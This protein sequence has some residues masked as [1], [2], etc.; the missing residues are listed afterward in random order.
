VAKLLDEEEELW[1]E[2]E[3]VE[4]AAD[5]GQMVDA[6]I[7]ID[8][9]DGESQDDKHKNEIEVIG[10]VGHLE[11]VGSSH[12]GGGAGTG[13][14]IHHGFKFAKLQDKSSPKLLQ[15]CA[16]GEHIK[17]AEFVVR[18]AGKQQQE[19]LKYTFSDVFVSGFRHLEKPDP[20]SHQFRDGFELSY[21]KF[22]M[23]YKEQKADGTLGGAVKSG[24]DVKARKKV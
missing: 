5:E 13:R 17:K 1:E 16:S 2:L 8:G 19:Y 11:N 15:A 9:I 6:F 7:K 23:E 12:A 3:N 14:S 10:W 18:K 22:E 20:T 21:G 24:Y 4:K